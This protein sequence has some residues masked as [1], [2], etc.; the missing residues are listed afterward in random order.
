MGLS[1]LF[2]TIF[3]YIKCVRIF[4]YLGKLKISLNVLPKIK[5]TNH[6]AK[7]FKNDT[8]QNQRS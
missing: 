2:C 6:Y 1:Y 5:N 8:N 3:Y 7:N 4:V